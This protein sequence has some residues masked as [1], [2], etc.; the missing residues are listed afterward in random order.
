MRRMRRRR[1]MMMMM[2][3]MKRMRR[4]MRRMVMTMMRRMM[5]MMMRRRSRRSRM[6]SVSQ[7]PCFS[8]CRGRVSSAM[9]MPMMPSA[10]WVRKRPGREGETERKRE[11]K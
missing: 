7:S 4:M 9:L 6:M 1:M 10:N 8:S 3:R 11:R 5:M 2:R